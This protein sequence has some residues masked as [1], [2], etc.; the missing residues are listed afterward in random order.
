M[1]DQ[2]ATNF[3]DNILYSVNIITKEQNESRASD[4]SIGEAFVTKKKHGLALEAL[5]LAVNSLP[6]KPENLK[7]DNLGQF[8]QAALRC[9][10]ELIKVPLHFDIPKGGKQLFDIDAFIIALSSSAVLSEARKKAIPEE[11]AKLSVWLND[12]DGINSLKVAIEDAPDVDTLK[13]ELEK[14]VYKNSIGTLDN[15]QTELKSAKDKAVF[16]LNIKEI[17]TDRLLMQIAALAYNECLPKNPEGDKKGSSLLFE[18]KENI[19]KKTTSIDN[20]IQEELD[21]VLHEPAFQRLEANWRALEYLI[22]QTDFSKDIKIDLLDVTKEELED[23]FAEN[24]RDIANSSLFKKLYTQEYDQYGGQP[25]SAM[26]GLYEFENSE[27][28]INWLRTMGK[29]ANASHCTFVSSV[30]PKFFVGHDDINQLAEIKNLESHMLQGKFSK[31]NEFRDSE[32]AAYLAFTVPRFMIRA[33]YHI[34]DNPVPGLNYSETVDSHT[35]YTWANAAMLF[36][37]NIVHS[38]EETSWCQTVRGPKNGGHI[39]NLASHTFKQ[40]GLTLTKVP[41]ELVMPDY[42]ELEFAKAGFMPLV[43]QKDTTNACFFSCQSIKKPKRFKDPRDTENSQLVTNLSYTLSITKIAHYIKCIMRDNIGGTADAP[44][45]TNTISNW[46]NSYVTTVVNPDDLTLRSYPFKAVNVET[47]AQEGD[48][49]WYKCTVSVSPHL[50]FEGL[51][52][53]LRLETQL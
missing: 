30:G 14:E 25:Y 2:I 34:E 35:H 8:K 48:I 36:A 1:S 43:Y 20:V 45:I 23:D 7:E 37:R 42:R 12:K 4:P 6:G 53:E 3:I 39:P 9:I 5:L 40:N 22:E 10:E 41:V 19:T 47:V 32:E 21:T 15:L 11:H 49:G 18:L 33:P 51:D 16:E 24:R 50:Q 46:L 17:E 28:D 27:R 38:Y 29:I 52:A 26:I 31:W 44:Y 13:A